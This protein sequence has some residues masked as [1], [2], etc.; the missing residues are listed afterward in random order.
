MINN[1]YIYVI[2]EI[3]LLLGVR[4]D[5]P[6]GNGARFKSSPI[7]TMTV[8]H[9]N[10]ATSNSVEI[11]IKTVSIS[12][13]LGISEDEAMR[14]IASIQNITRYPVKINEQYGWPRVG[15]RTMEE[16]GQ[17]IRAIYSMC[18]RNHG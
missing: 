5:L 14:Q 13:H 9:A 7:A 3:G 10:L 15:V 4:S 2:N 17:V 1:I 11:A 6:S 16:A 8:Y 12:N 18:L